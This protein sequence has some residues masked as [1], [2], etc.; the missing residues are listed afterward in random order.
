MPV[1]QICNLSIKSS[2]F[3]KDCKIAKL[4]RLNK[5]GTKTDPKNFRPK[6][7]KKVKKVGK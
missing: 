4:K 6:K 7:G 3:K 1:T 5:K 2:Q